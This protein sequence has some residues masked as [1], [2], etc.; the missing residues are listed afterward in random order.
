MKKNGKIF[1]V[2]GIISLIFIAPLF[3]YLVQPTL[4][5]M[6][7]R[8]ID[9]GLPY[10][11]KKGEKTPEYSQIPMDGWSY[12]PFRITPNFKKKEEEQLISL[13]KKLQ[14]EK[15]EKTGLKL[16][17]SDENT[18]GDFVKLL[19]L[20]DKTKQEFY[21]LDMENT[22][23]LYVLY[24]KP[25]KKYF[26]NDTVM[27]YLNQKDYDYHHASFY[28]KLINFSPKGIYYIILGYLLL[29]YSAILKPKLTLNIKKHCR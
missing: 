22:N 18:Y 8:V 27:D 7:L 23:S 21:G 2:S 14:T 13:I 24:M 28:E 26:G 5:E 10:K 20:M 3:W 4:K 17:F 25:E 1:Y 15:I 11:A 6:N 16:Q 29:V 12:K 9:I 19:N